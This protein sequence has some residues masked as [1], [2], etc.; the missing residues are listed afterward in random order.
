MRFLQ[1]IEKDTTKMCF[2][3]GDNLYVKN[4]NIVF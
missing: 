4:I 1:D 2:D 3:R